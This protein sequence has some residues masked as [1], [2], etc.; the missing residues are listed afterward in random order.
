MKYALFLFLLFSN[1]I[2]AQ[3]YEKSF[4]V[5]GTRAKVEFEYHSAEVAEQLIKQVIEE[6]NRIDRLMSPFKNTSELSRINLLAST[7]PITISDEMYQ[8]LKRSIEFS[9][10]TNG[11]FDITFKSKGFNYDYPKKIRP[12]KK[13]LERLVN[14]ID[15][16]NIKLNPESNTVFFTSKETKID[17]GG[18]AKGHAVDLSIEL[19]ISHGV[20]NAYVSAGGDSRVIGTKK[21]R[22]WYIGVKHP[23]DENKLIVNL[24]LQDVA[25]STSGDYERFFIQDNIR[26]HHIIDPSTGDSARKSQSVTII[27]SKGTDADAWSTSIFILG[28]KKGLELINQVDDV[29]AIINDNEG[30]MS[31]SEDIVSAN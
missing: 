11:A 16:Q 17:L 23:R 9:K 20:K 22:M 15:Y 6:M 24:P 31:F 4:D 18:I 14:N 27:A 5:M 7:K 3:W 2:S 10:I 30:R 28:A 13:E 8:L 29:S 19:L 21:D 25:I 26:Y 12:N 1:S